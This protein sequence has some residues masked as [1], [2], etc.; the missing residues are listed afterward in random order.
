[1]AGKP[2]AQ[3]S[4]KECRDAVR[5]AGMAPTEEKLREGWMVHGMTKE[6]FRSASGHRLTDAY[7]AFITGQEHHGKAPTVW[8]GKMRAR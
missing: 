3:W 2:V 6:G 1:M 8:W 5:S 7:I 4:L